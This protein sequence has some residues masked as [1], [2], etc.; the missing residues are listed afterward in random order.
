[1]SGHEKGI[2]KGGAKRHQ[3]VRRDS[4]RHKIGHSSS[5]SSWWCQAYFGLN[6]RRNARNTGKTTAYYRV[7]DYF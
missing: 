3:K 4:R 2:G 1:M 5:R 6:L 7:T